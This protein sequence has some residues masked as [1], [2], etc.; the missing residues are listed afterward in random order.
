MTAEEQEWE[1]IDIIYLFA[2]EDK[3]NTIYVR[4]RAWACVGVRVY[5]DNTK[6]YQKNI[7]SLCCEII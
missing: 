4:G 2:Q 6:Y 5:L 3:Y 7:Q 1:Q